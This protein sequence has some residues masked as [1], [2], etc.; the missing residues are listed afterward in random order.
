MLAHLPC[1]LLVVSSVLVFSR[2]VRKRVD[3]WRSVFMIFPRMAV[4][5]VTDIAIF[6]VQNLSIGRPGALIFTLGTILSAWGHP[7][8]PWEQ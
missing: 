8:G 3:F 7:R 6:G 5:L 2:N 4:T 1:W